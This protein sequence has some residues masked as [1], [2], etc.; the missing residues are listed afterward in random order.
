[1]ECTPYKPF[2]ARECPLY[3]ATSQIDYR[4]ALSSR[5]AIM[6]ANKH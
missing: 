5:F 6:F 4:S 2:C 1:M 3:I